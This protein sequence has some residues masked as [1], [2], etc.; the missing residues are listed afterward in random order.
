LNEVE[1]YDEEGDIK[2]RVESFFENNRR[3]TRH[4]YYDKGKIDYYETL[5][6]IDRHGEYKD[7]YDNGNIKSV[8]EYKD[9]RNGGMKHGFYKEYYPTG[10]LKV[11]GSYRDNIKD[12]RWVEYYKNGVV[13]SDGYHVK[14]KRF[15]QY[16]EKYVHIRKGGSKDGIW[17]YYDENKTLIKQET[18]S[19]GFKHGYYFE[20]NDDGTKSHLIFIHNK[21]IGQDNYINRLR[22]KL[23]NNQVVRF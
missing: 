18:W 6:N 7:F 9:D 1:I 16:G 4:Y 5:S 13:K 14:E 19:H 23:S 22:F 11:E 3:L 21:C 12:G 10:R 20:R 15:N 8:C 2:R 17:K